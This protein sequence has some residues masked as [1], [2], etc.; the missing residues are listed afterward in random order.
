MSEKY[1]NNEFYECL[2]RYFNQETKLIF[3]NSIIDF[4]NDFFRHSNEIVIRDNPDGYLK[5]NNKTIIIEHF[6]YDATKNNKKGSETRIEE[7]RINRKFK[8]LNS[9]THENQFIHEEMKVT[10]STEYLRDNFIKVFKEHNSKITQYKQALIKEGIALD[11]NEIT[12]LFCCEDKT[13]FGCLALDNGMQTFSVVDVKECL[14]LILKSSVDYLLL[15]NTYQNDK[16]MYL[17]PV[18]D[19]LLTFSK[20]KIARDIKMIDFKPQVL[21]ASI[22]IPN[23]N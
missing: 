14:N 4:M 1:N 6:E 16:Y 12:T 3:I 10:H 17:L 19:E 2:E 23:E 9:S 18:S 15:C 5:L 7:F 20:N 22:F 11:D 21:G 8:N 13:T